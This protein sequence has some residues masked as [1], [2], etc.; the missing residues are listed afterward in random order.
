VAG[1]VTCGFCAAWDVDLL[2]LLSSRRK[3]LTLLA[4]RECSF[5]MPNVRVNRPAEAGTVRPG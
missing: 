3:A 1:S 4:M 2:W 5:L